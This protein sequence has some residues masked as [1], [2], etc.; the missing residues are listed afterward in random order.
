MADRNELIER[1]LE[2]F[3]QKKISCTEAREF[4]RE[5]K[6]ELK[7]VGELCDGAG[8]KIFGCELGCF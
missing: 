6:I 7:D 8:V 3:P 1:L 2:K 4:A 5:L